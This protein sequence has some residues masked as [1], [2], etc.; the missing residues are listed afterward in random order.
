MDFE[1]QIYFVD[2][3]ESHETNA[4][5]YSS[6]TGVNQ[7]YHSILENKEANGNYEQC[8]AIARSLLNERYNKW[9]EF[10]HQGDCSFSGVYQPTLPKNLT[11]SSGGF[12]A[13]SQFY[14][15]FKFLNI[16]DTSSLQILQSA[17]TNLCSMGKDELEIFNDNR[18]IE[19]DALKMCFRSTFAL[20]MLRGFGFA[21]NDQITATSVINGHKIG[22]ALGSILYEINTLP[23]TYVPKKWHEEVITEPM[24]IAAFIGIMISS[25]LVGVFSIFAIRS[26]HHRKK[27][28]SKLD[29]VQMVTS[30]S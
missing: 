28:Y 25:I 14:E 26:N 19:E 6:E 9:C 21:M 29:D 4:N 1:S 11:R 12:L 22:W 2:G 24:G 27:G 15:V 7:L 23:W 8:A 3:Y 13:F 20:E 10:A 30:Y 18:M 17:T 16:P 5:S